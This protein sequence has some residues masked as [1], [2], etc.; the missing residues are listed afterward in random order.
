MNAHETRAAEIA[1]GIL[2]G[3]RGTLARAITLAESSRDDDQELA[4]QVITN[5]LPATGKAL[6]L[7]VSG[8]PGVG[9]SS[10]VEALGCHIL[11][12]H[13]VAVLAIDPSSPKTGGS[14]LG[15]KTHMEELA[16]SERAFIRPS[17]GGTSFGGSSFGGSSFGGNTLGGVAA[18]TREAILLCE[19]AGHDVVL[20]ETIGVGQSEYAVADLCDLLLLLVQPGAGDELQGIKRGIME[21]ADALVV[22][23]ADGDLTAPARRAHQDLV[24]A[25][26]VRHAS[27]PMPPVFVCS[28]RERTGFAEL[29]RE[30][31]ACHAGWVESGEIARRRAAQD[32]RWFE[33][34]IEVQVVKRFLAQSSVAAAMP[35]V[36]AEIRERRTTPLVAARRMVRSVLGG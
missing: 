30:I 29:W 25:I 19:A 1:A 22:T 14:I 20:V 24:A 6:R 35:I 28:A 23:K 12:R 34:E 16:R 36:I 31:S 9:K 11:D 10:F 2:R 7:G 26:H 3:E 17:P 15:D 18:H 32:L 5:V 33:R 21:V 27:A 8:P 13:K 4:S